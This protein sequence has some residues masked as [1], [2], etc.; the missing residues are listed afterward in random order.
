M[1]PSRIKL[2]DV[3]N[4]FWRVGKEKFEFFFE[5]FGFENHLKSWTYM[6]YHKNSF[7]NDYAKKKNSRI[8]QNFSFFRIRIIESIFRPIE[9][10]WRKL[11]FQLKVSGPFDSFPI[12]FDQSNLSSCTFRFLPDSSQLI[13][14]WFLKTY[15]NQI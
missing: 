13:G 1:L 7:S 9:M 2:L 6:S 10:W 5:K 15:R 3:F 12:P 8:F 4:A 14:F 11:G